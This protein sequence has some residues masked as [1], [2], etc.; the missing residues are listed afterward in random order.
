MTIAYSIDGKDKLK[1]A[2]DEFSKRL[3]FLGAATGQPHLVVPAQ[4]IDYA[5]IERYV[6]RGRL[7]RASAIRDGFKLATA[8]IAKGFVSF[9]RYFKN[10]YQYRE[11]IKA[12]YALNDHMLKDIGL[13]RA[14]VESLSNGAI[15]VTQFNAQR[16]LNTN[17]GTVS[18]KVYTF[19]PAR[20]ED[21]GKVMTEARREPANIDIAA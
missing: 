6:V 19:K 21:A 9:L 18:C 14:N 8:G 4:N 20:S 1:Q 2:S 12:L 3:G 5:V 11:D 13:T 7:M 17:R 10:R 16:A 15:S